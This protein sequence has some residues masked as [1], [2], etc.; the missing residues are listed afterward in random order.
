MHNFLGPIPPSPPSN[1]SLGGGWGGVHPVLPPKAPPAV[2]TAPPLHRCPAPGARSPLTGSEGH[3][4]PPSSVLSTASGP[5]SLGPSPSPVGPNPTSAGPT[6]S[7]G[8][9]SPGY[10]PESDR[11]PS[12]PCGPDAG[13]PARRGAR[14]APGGPA[15]PAR[16]VSARAT[17]ASMQDVTQ[18]LY[19]VY[20]ELHRAYRSVSAG[21]APWMAEAAGPVALGA[22]DAAATGLDGGDEALAGHIGLALQS[23]MCNLLDTLKSHLETGP[24]LQPPQVRLCF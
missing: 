19:Q 7:P 5:S 16:K 11:H 4:A 14:D 24:K 23:A 1:T 6:P 9:P 15:R 3:A 20:S 2:K 17:A 12:T 10:T 18:Q 21:D 22:V 8:G 13:P